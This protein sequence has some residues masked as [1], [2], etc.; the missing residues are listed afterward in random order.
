MKC[1]NPQCGKEFTPKT[2]NHIYCSTRCSDI[3]RERRHCRYDYIS[4]PC[5]P[6][7]KAKPQ[8]KHTKSTKTLEQWA[9]EAAECNLDYGTYRGL[10]QLGK[11]YEELKATADNRHLPAHSSIKRKRSD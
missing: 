3:A 9:R 11:T 10:I 6:K 2:Y 1:A 5:V 7:F 4:K 8:P